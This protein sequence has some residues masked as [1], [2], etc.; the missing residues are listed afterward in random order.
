MVLIAACQAVLGRQAGRTDVTVG[1]TY[2]T[3]D[4]PAA[5]DAVGLF[6]NLAVLRGDTSGDPS[7]TELVERVREVALDGYEARDVPFAR[8]ARELGADRDPSRTPLFQ[9]LVDL[10]AKPRRRPALAGLEVTE[11]PDRCP[12]SK[13]DLALA[14]DGSAGGLR[15]QLAWDTALYE[16]AT[17]TR[18]ADDL[19]TML[20]E[21]GRHPEH[22]LSSFHGTRT[23]EVSGK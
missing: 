12:G 22:R 10:S 11:F 23:T 3:R 20:I 18:L 14:F 7:F 4:D 21:A 6:V 5:A 16:A 9:I 19:R 13:Y 1:S 17:M 2:S 15:A 8:V